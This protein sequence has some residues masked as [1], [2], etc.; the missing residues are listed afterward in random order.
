MDAPG[1]SGRNTCLPRRMQGIK[2]PA[3]LALLLQAGLWISSAIA[4][5]RKACAI[6]VASVIPGM[7]AGAP[8]MVGAAPEPSHPL[9]EGGP[10]TSRRTVARGCVVACF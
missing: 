3:A 4:N 8:R 1:T 10:R 7:N 6:V 2:L 5:D 9:L